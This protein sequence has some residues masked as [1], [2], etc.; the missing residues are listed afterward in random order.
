MKVHNTLGKGFRE[1]V[2]KDAFEVE[3]QKTKIPY[4]REK[5]FKI[6]YEG[7]VLNHSFDADFL[8]Y[9]SIILEI[10]ASSSLHA[11]AFRQTLNYLKSSNIKLGLL[12][13]FWNR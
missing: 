13:K 5:K 11:D 2:Y 12:V 10:K 4:D 9:Q 7:I 1:S 6:E 3:L 8:L